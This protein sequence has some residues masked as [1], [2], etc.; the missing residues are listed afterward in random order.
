MEVHHHPH[1]ERKK[2]THYLWEFLMLFLAVFCGFL[3]ENF[4]EHRVEHQRERQYMITMLE[5]LQSDTSL[6][7]E[8]VAFWDNINNSIDSV[9]DAIQF[10]LSRTDFPK[11][12]RHLSR[13]L[14]YY[15]FNY[16]ERTIAQL[17]NSG[18]FRLIRQ[19]EVANK[20]T[21]YDQLNQNALKK[22]DAQHNLLY[23]QTLALRNRVFVQEITNEVYRRYKYIP[24]PPSDH[25]WIDSM[26]REHKIPVSQ[27]AYGALMFEFKN[28]LLALRKD[29]TNM[30]WGY[31]HEKIQMA[32]LISL[33][34]DK[35]HVK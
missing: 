35:Y 1:T 16:N 34:Q 22:I 27:E 5:D 25:K 3:A 8:C 2:F 19:R 29:F 18:G 6:L 15:G 17:K 10:P 23:M 21:L 30:K 20:I 14:N 4:R 9:S 12:Y 32:E 11:A 33:I 13:A 24:P 28:S 31:D 26:I 7:A